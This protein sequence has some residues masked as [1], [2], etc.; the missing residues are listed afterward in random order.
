MTVLVAYA[1]AH[2]S[3]TEI[4]RQL[5][6]RFGKSGFAAVARPVST[7]TSI[8]NYHAVVLGSALRD[9]AWQPEATEFLARFAG[10]SS[11]RPVWLFSTCSVADD[12]RFFEST[13][14]TAA[15]RHEVA[16]AAGSHD[17]IPLRDYHHFPGGYEPR[18]WSFIADLWSKLCGGFSVD[19]RDWHDVNEWADSIVRQLLIADRVK[20]RRRL[21]ISVRGRP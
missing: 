13:A 9:H 18:R 15:H 10:E 16:T 6:D 21:R 8:Q 17:P 20:E 4:A 19:Q 12:G 1:C 7:I 11:R 3:T 14:T 5:A 2:E